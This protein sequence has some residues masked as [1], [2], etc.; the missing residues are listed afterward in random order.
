MYRSRIRKWGLDKNNKA[1]EVAYM[2]N[3]KKHRDAAGKGSRFFIR[4]RPID[5]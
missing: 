4:N 3:M 1:A 2:V 5:W